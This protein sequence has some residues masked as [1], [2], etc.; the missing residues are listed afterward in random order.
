M[1]GT[2]KSKHPRLTNREIFLNCSIIGVF[3]NEE[4][5]EEQVY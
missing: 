2:A 5:M 1:L 3:K 4:D